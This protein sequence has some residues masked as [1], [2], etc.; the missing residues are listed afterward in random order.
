MDDQ[1][2]PISPPT[3]AEERL[4]RLRGLVANLQAAKRNEESIKTN[5]IA[6]EGM[7]AELIPGREDGQVTETLPDGSKIVV[8]R[9]FNYKADLDEI[10]GIL[11]SCE[12]EMPI[13]IEVK[14][15]RKLDVK[16]YEWYRENYP[17]LSVLL[18]QHVT[19]TPKKVAV[20]L[21][22]PKEK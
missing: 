18:T 13:P 7:I 10:E 21:K 15:T 16:G 4:I 19:V 1:P 6:L 17:E 14:T 5:R 8:K 22:N 20:E 12:K 11:A 9:G 3:P 2:Q